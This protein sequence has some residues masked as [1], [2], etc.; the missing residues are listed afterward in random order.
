VRRPVGAWDEFTRPGRLSGTVYYRLGVK[1]SV[2]ESE[3]SCNGLQYVGVSSDI[4]Q[5]FLTNRL[6]EIGNDDDRLGRL[7][8]AAADVAA[9]LLSD[10]SRTVRYVSAAFD[11]DTPVDEPVLADI[12]LQVE[13]HWNTYLACFSDT[14]RVLYRAVLLEALRQ[15]Q[16]KD[17]R[18]ATAVTL[19]CKNLVPHFNVGSERKI[20]DEFVHQ[21]TMRAE[22]HAATHWSGEIKAPTVEIEPPRLATGI[23]LPA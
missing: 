4:L 9:V 3:V 18:I 15:A 22:A 12:A 19:T 7:R 5:R 1:P 10:R 16:E 20:W 11:P 13:K 23:C 8:G 14:P 2:S 17:V 21:A 6:F